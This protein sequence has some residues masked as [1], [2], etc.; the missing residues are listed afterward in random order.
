MV[1]DMREQDIIR[2][3]VSPWASPVV[4]VP[5]KDG[6]FRFCVDYRRLNS[7][8]KKDVFPLPRIDDILDTLGRAKYFTSLDLASGYWQVELDEESREKSAFT[9]HCGLYEFTR[10]PFGLCN[11]PATFQ[12]L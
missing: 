6:K 5:K 2:P 4:L 1:N 10:M 7:V 11:A 12:R 9:T 8:T 3:S